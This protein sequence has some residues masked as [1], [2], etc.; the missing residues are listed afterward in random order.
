M[1]LANVKDRQS[2]W[3]YNLVQS[4]VLQFLRSLCFASYGYFL[5]LS[6]NSVRLV[7]E[8]CAE[9]WSSCIFHGRASAPTCVVTCF[10]CLHANRR[11]P[12]N[13][14][15]L[16]I[17]TSVRSSEVKI[18]YNQM[19]LPGITLFLTAEIKWQ[20]SNDLERAARCSFLVFP[21]PIFSL[22]T[23]IWPETTDIISRLFI[24]Y[25]F[26]TFSRFF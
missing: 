3:K 7:Y 2:L 25:C 8:L 23:K 18:D 21:A 5:G 4:M 9:M 12:Q 24:F 19:L 22:A 17:I 6:N 10:L 1:A 20:V 26:L 14:L 13:M 16:W 15:I 11:T